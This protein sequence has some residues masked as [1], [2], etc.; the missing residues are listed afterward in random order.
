MSLHD[1]LSVPFALA[2]LAWAPAALAKPP[3]AQHPIQNQQDEGEEE[4][5]CPEAVRGVDLALI[6]VSGGARMDFTTKHKEQVE[7]LRLLLREAGATM[8][9]HSKLIALH[10]DLVSSEDEVIPPVDVEVKD[11][12]NGIEVTIRAESSSDASRVM[13]HARKLKEA[14]G[15]NECVR[16]ST[17]A[18]RTRI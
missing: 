18:E 10:P 4:E 1:K 9:Y 11:L 12:P 2:A 8:E 3:P 14:W 16:E 6:P 7:D 13:Q 15:T 17:S 5:E